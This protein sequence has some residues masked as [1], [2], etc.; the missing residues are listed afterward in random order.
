MVP[1]P[2][3]FCRPSRTRCSRRTYI[4]QTPFAG[5]IA[6]A[7][8]AVVSLDQFE[9]GTA[10]SFHPPLSGRFAQPYGL[11]FAADATVRRHV[12]RTLGTA[13]ATFAARVL[14]RYRRNSTRNAVDARF[15]ADLCS[16]IRRSARRKFTRCTPTRSP[17]LEALTL[18]VAPAARLASRGCGALSQ[19]EPA[20]G[21]M[22]KR[23]WLGPAPPA[24]Q[25]AQHSP[26][27]E[28]GD[29]PSM[30]DWHPSWK[31]NATPGARWR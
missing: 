18:A 19:C 21:A 20:Y 31:S 24:R 30:V 3:S 12:V 17:K 23:R 4:P 29:P 11:L 2:E 9:R 1:P 25:G 16:R 13:V 14:P 8:F 28:G 27:A 15:S 5:R 10:R 6:R 22:I 26:S 7:K